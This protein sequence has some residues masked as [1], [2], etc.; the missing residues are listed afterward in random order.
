MDATELQI[1][2]ARSIDALNA[3]LKGELSAV[4]THRQ[5]MAKFGDEAPDEL[6][7]SLV[8]HQLRA[9]RISVRIRDLGGKPAETSGAWG[10]FARLVEGGAAFFG[11]KSALAA[12][13][14]GEDH[15]LALYRDHLDDLDRESRSLA[16]SLLLP[17]QMKSRDHVRNLY[18]S[19]P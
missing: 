12:L 9:Q 5:A 15:G 1:D 18:R 11:R 6:D 13:D 3:L 2:R 16:E 10:A 7:L 14:E 17:E 4:E 19:C 8:S